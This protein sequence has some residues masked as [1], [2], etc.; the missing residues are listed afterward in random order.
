MMHTLSMSHRGRMDPIPYIR[1]FPNL[2][3]LRVHCTS[4]INNSVHEDRTSNA[5]SQREVEHLGPASQRP[6]WRELIQFNGTLVDLYALAL[7]CHIAHIRLH[8]YTDDKDLPLLSTVL[9]DARPIHLNIYGFEGILHHP[10]DSLSAV[11]HTQGA[12][13]LE[14]LVVSCLIYG[15]TPHEDVVSALLTLNL[16]DFM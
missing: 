6:G 1:A 9:A 7:N 5:R 8:D 16:F 11:L 14:S 2:A 3:H 13:H 15:Y 12:S 4:R 10:T